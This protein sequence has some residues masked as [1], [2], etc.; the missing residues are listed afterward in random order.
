[1]VSVRLLAA[2]ALAGCATA[3]P[4]TAARPEPTAFA[5]DTAR[6]YTEADVRFVQGMIG[7]HAQALVMTSL[8]P[9]RTARREL[10]LLAERIEVSQRDEIATMERWLSARGEA[11]PAAHAGHQHGPMPGMLTPEEL[12]RLA[13]ASGAEFDR[14]FLQFMIRHHEGALV[15]V[16]E[17]LQSPGAGQE[18][19]LFQFASDVDADQRAEIA[20]MQALLGTIG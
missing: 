17:L 5:A 2:A 16:R 11:V 4:P 15:M 12:A 14:L 1:M 18:S 3:A 20:R 7:H 19:Q 8:V 6:A 9:Q 13:A 10:H